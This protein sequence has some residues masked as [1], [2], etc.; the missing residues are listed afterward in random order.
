MLPHA[1][2]TTPRAGTL[3]TS[4]QSFEGLRKRST[5]GSEID[6]RP[7]VVAVGGHCALVGGRDAKEEGDRKTR[8]VVCASR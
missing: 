8:L 6:D 1:V 2:G 5:E 7:S 4:S 3:P